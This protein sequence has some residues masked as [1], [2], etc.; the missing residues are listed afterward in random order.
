MSDDELTVIRLVI[1]E[2]LVSS[3]RLDRLVVR[4]STGHLP[5]LLRTIVEGVQAGVF[6]DR[7]PLPVTAAAAMVILVGPQIVRRLLGG[8]LPTGMDVASPESLAQSLVDILLHGIA[9]R[10]AI[11]G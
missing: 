4:F 11:K 8:K 2:A 6:G 7:H 10:P 3:T 1:R 5:M 9:P